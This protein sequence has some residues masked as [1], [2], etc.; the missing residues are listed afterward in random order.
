VLTVCAAVPL[1]LLGAEVTTKQVGMV[2]R[3]GFRPPWHLLSVPFRAL[4][5][6]YLIEHA[7]RLA[8]FLVGT[9]S[10]VL[11]VGL[12]LK[13]R[14]PLLRW[15]GWVALAAVSLQGVLGIFRVDLDYLFGPN[16]AL[17]HGLFAQVT[18]AVLV[19]VA[20]MTSRAWAGAA[21]NDPALRRLALVFAILVYAQIAFGALVRHLTSRPAQRA[22]VLFAFVVVA[23]AVWLLRAV[24]EQKRDRPLRRTAVLLGALL[25]LQLGL[26]VEAWVGRFGSGVLPEH[27]NSPNLALDAVRS[28]HFVIGTLLFATAVAL[29]LLS[30]RPGLTQLRIADRGSRTASES[31]IRNPQSAIGVGSTL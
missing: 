31:A 4:G 14:H 2:D 24:W 6:G 28:G 11:A 17:V 19:S 3:V 26:G 15:M 9:C 5:L 22:H 23:A 13:A 8:G 1:V 10:I 20:V 27:M 29:A 30:Y 21:V 7:H 12:W 25:V 16:L 18:F